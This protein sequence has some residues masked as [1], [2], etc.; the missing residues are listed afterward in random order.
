MKQGFYEQL[1]TQALG[2]AIDQNRQHHLAIESFTGAD[3][4]VLLNRFFQQIFQRVFSRLA[5]GNEEEAKERIIGL[6]NDLIRLMSDRI[7]DASLL[8]EQ[9][10]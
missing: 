8:D 9:L 3:G 1:V 6:A 4:A 7:N 5:T 2:E 10:H